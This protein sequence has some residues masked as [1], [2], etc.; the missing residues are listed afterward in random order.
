MLL[1]VAALFLAQVI[2]VKAATVQEFVPQGWTL[3]QH[4][5][6]DL[7][8]D[9]R[10]DVLILLRRAPGAKGTPERILAV[11]L[12]ASGASPRYELFESNAQLFPRSDDEGQED[13]MADGELLLRP[14]GFEVKFSLMSSAGSYQ[15]MTVR[16]RFRFDRDCFRLIGYDRM[17]THRGTLDTRDTSVN[18]LSGAVIQRTGNAESNRMKVRR[19][20]LKLNPRQCFGKLE[21]AATFSPTGEL[22]AP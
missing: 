13:P 8:G 17:E 6:G 7:N 20:K 11:A 19:D 2:P 14:R 18:F 15:T 21:S 9:G 4:K 5:V 3:E 1:H 10:R 16:Y 12:R 22:V